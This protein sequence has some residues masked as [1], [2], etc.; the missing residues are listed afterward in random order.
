MVCLSYIGVEHNRDRLFLSLHR[1]ILLQLC[2]DDLADQVL[3]VDRVARLNLETANLSTVRCGNDH[4][5][6]KGYV[7]YMASEENEYQ[8]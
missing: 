2:L 4:F 7:S 3:A 6:E 1:I 5:L 8:K